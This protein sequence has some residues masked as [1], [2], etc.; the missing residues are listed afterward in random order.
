MELI[1]IRHTRLKIKKGICYG[2]S[3]VPV[4][5]TF[6]K[7]KKAILKNLDLSNARTISSPLKR[8]TKLAGCISENYK[9]DER[10]M[11]L[12]FGDWEMQKWDDIKDPE[13]DIWMNNYIEYPCPNGESLL[14][15]K[16]R[17]VQFYEDLKLQNQQK[18]III[19]HGGVIRLFYHIIQG[20]ELDKIFNVKIKFGEIHSFNI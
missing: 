14:S 16:E 13:L 17:V 15:M 1:L 7:E 12:N 11:E 20:V 18:W 3:E 19:T 2:Q 5:K 10:I 4:D 8:C 9:T 6:E